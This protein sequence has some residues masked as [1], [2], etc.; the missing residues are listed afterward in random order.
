[1]N[2]MAHIKIL[3][4]LACIRLLL[5]VFPAVA[6]EPSLG[7]PVD[8]SPG[9]DCWIAQYIDHDSSP[10]FQDFACGYRTY[11]KHDGTDIALKDRNSMSRDVHVLA[12]ADGKVVRLR[13][14][15]EDHYGTAAD[16]SA[17]KAAK[18]E[19]GN[20]VSLL[21]DGGWVTEY[22]HMKKGSVAVTQGQYVHKGDVLGSV[23][24]SGMAEFAHVHF[25][26][27]HRNDV[28][29]PFAG[30][31]FSGCGG[32]THPMWET[33]VSYDP[34]VVY[35][36][37]F[38]DSEP[39]F[40]NLIRDASFPSALL[41]SADKLIF[42]FMF[43]GAEPG[44]RIHAEILDPSGQVYVQNENIQAKRQAQVMRLIGKKTAGAPLKIG[45]Y[46]G[47]ATV[48][49]KGADGREIERTLEQQVAIKE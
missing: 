3:R 35:A 48:T 25:S 33:A 5:D 31:E 13:D 19:C 12:A 42:W 16:I 39:D 22:C 29:D 14:G 23:G 44:D 1:M 24:Q 46:K 7:W 10:S 18:K 37:G 17:V 43:Y 26:V 2:I 49:R 27:R 47:R 32:K 20:L 4:V 40:D 9:K 41:A 6:A 28:V 15:M 36:A 8:C 34:F 38:S 21:H 45:T 30:T 11:D